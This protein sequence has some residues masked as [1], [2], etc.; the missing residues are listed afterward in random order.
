MYILIFYLFAALQVFLGYKS[1][2]GGIDYLRYFKDQLSDPKQDLQ[3]F[4]TVIAPCKGIDPDLEDN[5]RA[6]FNQDYDEYEVIFVTDREDDDCAPIVRRLAAEQ[7]NATWVIA[8]VA[9]S[10]GQKT[11]NLRKATA[12][13]GERSEIFVFVDSDAR[14]SRNWL[15][16]LVS[17]L[18]EKS[19]G[20]ATGYRWFIQ[21]RGGFFTHLRS[22]WNASIASALGPNTSSNFCWGGSMAIRRETFE[23]LGLSDV[24]KDVL[25]DDFAV[26]KAIK[27]AGLSIRFV[28][29]CLTATVEDTSFR[30]FMEFTNRQMKITRVYAPN[31]WLASLIG[32]FLFCATLLSALILLFVAEGVYF[33]TVVAFLVII[34]TLGIAKA[35]LRM[36]AVK[37]VLTEYERALKRQF[38]WQITLW[39]VSPLLFLV[40]DISA[41]FSRKI[42]WRGIEYELK[43][44]REVLIIS[45]N[46]E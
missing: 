10:S 34:L 20:C 33:W 43:S 27:E 23:E 7:P 26:T 35:W 16:S 42:I 40:N 29:Q 14:P 3:P 46:D 1:L 22:V 44:P 8:G 30:G 24:W 4:T 45:R 21:K 11:H 28:P 9:A 39:V 6:L 5:L 36:K 37:L 12:A 19:V 15:R 31:L 13:S 32:S 2:R 17:P 18:S 25:S 38:P 41:L